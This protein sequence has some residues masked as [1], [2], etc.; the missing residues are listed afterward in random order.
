M[1]VCKHAGVRMFDAES[2]ICEDKYGGLEIKVDRVLLDLRNTLGDARHT[3][4][5]LDRSMVSR[6]RSW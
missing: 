6:F 4:S 2:Y 1:E 3:Q 5:C